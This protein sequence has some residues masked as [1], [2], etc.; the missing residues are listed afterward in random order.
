MVWIQI[1]TDG[2]G[3]DLGPNSAQQLSADI[4][5]LLSRKQLKENIIFT[6][7]LSHTSQLI[8]SLYDKCICALTLIILDIFVYH[9]P[10]QILSSCQPLFT[11]GVENSDDPDMLA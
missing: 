1:R 7:H 6:P 10:S 4:K 9:T 2:I 5:S 11:S 8:Q 3:P